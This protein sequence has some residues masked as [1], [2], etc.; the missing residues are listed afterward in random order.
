[1]IMKLLAMT[2]IAA[3]A[4]VLAACSAASTPH[5]TPTVT[6]PG[7]TITVTAPAPQVTVTT[8]ATIQPQTVMSQDGVYVVGIDIKRGVYHT[9]GASPSGGGNCYYALLSSTSTNDIIDN[10]N[11]T[12][13]ATIT[14]RSGV[15]AVDVSGC[16][17]W[18]KIG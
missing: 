12:G 4:L 14:V 10:N 15:K 11:V 5:A 13:P 1:M 9:T 18:Q 16:N 6:V 8:T 7:P 2:G 17:P 3:S